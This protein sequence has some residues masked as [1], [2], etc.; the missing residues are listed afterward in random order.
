M[1]EPTVTVDFIPVS[2]DGPK[3]HH[4]FVIPPGVIDNHP[5]T[6]VHVDWHLR[7]S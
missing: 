1:N 3:T 4:I 5:V 2:I 7:S 6:S